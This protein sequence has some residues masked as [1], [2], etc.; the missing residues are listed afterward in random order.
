MQRGVSPCAPLAVV[1][2]CWVLVALLHCG[3]TALVHQS[4]TGG[5]FDCCTPRQLK[6]HPLAGRHRRQDRV[7]G[8]VGSHH[9]QAVVQVASLAPLLVS[10]RILLLQST[11][12]IPL[13]IMD[14]FLIQ[15]IASE[16]QILPLIPRKV[17][18]GLAES[19]VLRPY[20]LHRLLL[21]TN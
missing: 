9:G 4:A 15:L 8:R 5:V 13:E 2:C 10:G 7:C 11:P 21:P 16:F 6:L 14:I 19:C 3:E 18:K 1:F 17:L 12:S 20:V